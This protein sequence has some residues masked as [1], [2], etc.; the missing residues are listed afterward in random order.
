MTLPLYTTRM[1]V[2]EGLF[3]VRGARVLVTGAASGLGQAMA[4][5]MVDG[6]ASVTLADLDEPRL[7]EVASALRARDGGDVRTVTLDVADRAQVDAAVDAIAADQG[8][9]DVAFANAGISL[10]AGFRDPGGGI[11]TINPEAWDRVLKVNL[12]GVI[13]TMAAAA[14]VMKEQRS[15]RIVVTASTAGLRTDPF[16][17]YS[18]ATTKAA[19]VSAARQAALELAPHG[20]HVNVIAPGPIRTRIGGGV[21]PSREIEEMWAAT[22]PLGRMGEPDEIKGVCLL[23]ASPA[24]SWITGAVIPIDGGALTTSHHL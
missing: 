18:Y 9:L 17:G 23:L 13:A 5:V 15:G 6:G 10:E 21:L 22:V 16:V 12:E 2:P 11:T 14:R 8:G 1:A 7:E 19:V 24:S 20:V 4:E 3:D